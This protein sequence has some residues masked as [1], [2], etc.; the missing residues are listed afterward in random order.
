MRGRNIKLE[1]EYD[2]TN[3]CG[4]QVQKNSRK[5][6][7]QEVIEKTLRKIIGEKVKLI[8][9]GRTDAGVHALAQ[10]A[11]FFTRSKI[12]KARLK[13]ALNGLLPKD[14]KV[15][16]V[17]DV[18]LNF[19]SR[20]SAKAKVYRYTIL[21]RD[22][23]SALLKDQVYYCPY[24]LDIGAMRRESQALLGKHNFLAFKAADKKAKNP[25]KRINRIS[26][27]KKGDLI[28]IDIEADGFLYNMARNIAG[29]LI[30]IGRGR[31]VKAS[32][33]RILASKNRRLAGPTLDARGLCL[34]RVKY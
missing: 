18:S 21:N 31:F 14:I 26:I 1:I 4:W 33:K 27:T 19:H 13:I 8:A 10:V 5:K 29:T 12:P 3:Y 7:I 32:L 2:G 15:A 11:N 25:F 34:V 30:E 16:R 22:Y 20:F 6:S 17:N 24:T 23:S 28:R 9:A